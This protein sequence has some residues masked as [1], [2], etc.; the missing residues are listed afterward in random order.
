MT[1]V[2]ETVENPHFQYVLGLGDD[3]LILGQRLSECLSK[4]PALEMDIAVSNLSL[5]LIGQA[6]LL[7]GY[8]G[9]IEG[10]GRSADELVNF[11]DAHDYRCHWLVEQPDRDWG[12][13]I[14]RQFL[15]SSYQ[16][17]LFERLA[18]LEDKE[19]AEIAA[20]A[21]K[22][23]AYHRR[24]SAE[25]IVRLG[26]GTEESNL[27]V[28]N[29]INELWRYTGELFE[30]TK[31]EEALAKEGKAILASDVEAEWVETID[32]VFAKAGLSKLDDFY[33]VYGRHK[34]HHSEYLGHMLC[35]MQYLQ[36][37]YPGAEW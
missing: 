33:M 18:K 9:K 10:K 23:I 19:L 14:C 35:E 12:Y 8:A 6:D 26:Q 20:K 17:L 13:T 21:L 31:W 30:T 7:L 22:E 4:G 2:Y 28:Q 32:E 29:A 27:R 11:R 36:R 5:D 25:W 16:Y 15:F 37:A 24:F 3:S 34:G 1:D